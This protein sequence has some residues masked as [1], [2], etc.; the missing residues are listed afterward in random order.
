MARTAIAVRPLSRGAGPL[1]SSASVYVLVDRTNGMTFPN[2]GYTFLALRNINGATTY[3]MTFLPNP[4]LLFDGIAPAGFPFTAVANSQRFLGPFPTAKYGSTVNFDIL[5]AGAE[6]NVQVTAYSMAGG[7]NRRPP[8]N[9][10]TSGARIS[11][12]L[13]TT[14]GRSLNGLGYGS[15]SGETTGDV[16]NDHTF[17][18]D[19]QVFLHVRNTSGGG[20]VIYCQDNA[21]RDGQSLSNSGTAYTPMASGEERLIGPFPAILNFQPGELAILN[22][23]AA[24]QIKAYWLPFE[25]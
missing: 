25:E 14:M 9:I 8:Q 20:L 17:A 18:N 24:C 19:G 4:A 16:A 10:A 22:I 15:G 3:D 2:D 5:T 12:P 21:V 6:T 23:D 1:I 7:V 13:V 11:I